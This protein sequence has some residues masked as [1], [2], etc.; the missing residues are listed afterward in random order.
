[1]LKNVKIINY[2]EEKMVIHKESKGRF[3]CKDKQGENVSKKWNKV[4][5]KLCLKKKK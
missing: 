4:T 5:C 3:L 2:K 1:M